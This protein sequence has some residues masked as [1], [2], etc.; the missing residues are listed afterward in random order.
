VS[1]RPWHFARWPALAWMETAIKAGAFAAAGFGIAEGIGSRSVVLWSPMSMAR[2]AVLGVLSLGLVAAIFDRWR[3]RE[4]FAMGFVVLNS[5]AHWS[6]LAG[7]ILGW[8]V[9]AWL[10]LFAALMLAGDLTKI[11]FLRVHGFTVRGASAARMIAL[12]AAYVVGYAAILGLSI[13]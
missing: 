9:L 2:V 13:R 12:T 7:L 4:C 3:E 6:L 10:T 8:P 1:K 5:A 11:V